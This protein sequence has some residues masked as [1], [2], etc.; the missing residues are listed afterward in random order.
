MKKLLLIFIL[1]TSL[2][3][4]PAC[5]KKEPVY[6]VE[7]MNGKEYVVDTVNQT[8]Q[9]GGFTYSYEISLSGD[10]ITIEYPNGST[11]WWQQ[12]GAMGHG[13]W[14]NDYDPAKYPSDGGTLIDVLEKEAPR[15]RS[16]KSFVPF[17]LFL[18]AGAVIYKT[19]NTKV[20]QL[21]GIGKQ[22]PLT[23]WFFTFAAA[24]LVGIPPFSGFISKWY[25]AAGALES[26]M[27]VFSWL[28]PAVLLVSALLTAGYLLPISVNG[29]LPGAD[30]DYSAL[31]KA[32]PNW[33]MLAPLAILG[34]LAL[35][36]G[37]MPGALTEYI[38]GIVSQVM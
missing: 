37:L 35:V 6:T 11:Y 31:K 32:E 21:K 7:L 9:E 23:V 34:L 13:G 3:L 18:F 12:N 25:L 1:C 10:S 36:L 16:D 19:G 5:G 26:G 8:I 28:A 15:Q 2:L 29:F 17:F 30:F 27:G 38:A 20:D 14:S 33:L 4:L 24:A 22:M